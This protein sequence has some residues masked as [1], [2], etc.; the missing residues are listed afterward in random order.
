MIKCK[1]GECLTVKHG[2]AFK[3]RFFREEGQQC[4]LTPGNFYEKGGF[5]PNNGKE[6]YYS[7]TY[8]EE[9]LCKKGD[10]VVAMTQQS[11][12]LLGST[13]IVPE[14]NKYLHNQRIGLITCDVEKMNSSFAY[15]LF[16]TQVVR[17]QLE[18]TSSGTKVK[19][20]SPERISN[21]EVEIP[22]LSNQKKIAYILMCIDAKISNNMSIN[23]NLAA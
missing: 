12:G 19:H 20:T 8:P 18:R 6:R 7:G 13:A 21:I 9:Y 17:K 10:L 16:M 1:L 15:Y 4:I 14:D 5:K 3:G 2:W 22:D 11:E 23:D